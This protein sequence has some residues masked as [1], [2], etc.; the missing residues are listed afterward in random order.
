MN[1]CAC[2]IER[3]TG[4]EATQR[5]ERDKRRKGAEEKEEEQEVRD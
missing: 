3:E 5:R 1:L 4:K 2:V